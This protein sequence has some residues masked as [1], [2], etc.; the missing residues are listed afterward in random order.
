MFLHEYSL[1]KLLY[2]I[3]SQ[4]D[5]KSHQR[6]LGIKKNYILIITI[7]NAHLCAFCIFDF[8]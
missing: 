8:Y 5:I 2:N 4:F 7:E 3:H 1:R 6:S